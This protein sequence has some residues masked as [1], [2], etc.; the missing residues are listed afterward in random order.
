[1]TK[2]NR[3]K[4]KKKHIKNQDMLFCAVPETTIF[5]VVSSAHTG[6][7]LAHVPETTIKTVVS[8]TWGDEEKQ[9]EDKEEANQEK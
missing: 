4:K 8:G 1:M 9:A 7:V 3:Q 2:R 6:V 5:I